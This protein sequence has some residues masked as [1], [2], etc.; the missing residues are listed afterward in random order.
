MNSKYKYG[1]IFE[2]YNMDGEIHVGTGT[3]KVH[4]IFN[5]LPDFMKKADIIFCD[6]PYNKSALSSYYT[7]ADLKGK[8][9]ETFDA[10]FERFLIKKVTKRYY[11]CNDINNKIFSIHRC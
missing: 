6:P 7:K 8:G 4:D 2:K 5:P 9:P 10:F 11:S 1:D 3:V